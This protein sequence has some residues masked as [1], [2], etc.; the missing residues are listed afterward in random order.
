MKFFSSLMLKNF[1]SH[2]TW[3]LSWTPFHK[4]PPL[5]QW[6]RTGR[7]DKRP[8]NKIKLPATKGFTIV[9]CRLWNMVHRSNLNWNRRI[10]PKFRCYM[11]ILEKL[12]L[13]IFGKQENVFN[14]LKFV[15][16]RKLNKAWRALFFE[17]SR[18][19]LKL[20]FN[21]IRVPKYVYS[22]TRSITS[23]PMWKLSANFLH[24]SERL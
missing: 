16:F 15:C 22:C 21:E 13:Q 2:L 14:L 24:V 17:C 19:T 1:S 20:A 7:A 10:H 23:L 18:E 4:W 12:S 11:I 9:H 8:V 5:F 3:K 6:T